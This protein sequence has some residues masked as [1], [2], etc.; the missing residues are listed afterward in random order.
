MISMKDGEVKLGIGTRRMTE[1]VK[2]D[3]NGD[4]YIP[5]PEKMAKEG[6]RLFIRYVSR[7]ENKK[8][9][10]PDNRENKDYDIKCI[11]CGFEWEAVDEEDA[12]PNSC[13]HCRY[14]Y[15]DKPKGFRPPIWK[16][17]GIRVKEVKRVK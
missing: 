9:F 17:V 12:K 7:D 5:I 1:K 4:L 15:W 16:N 3:E 2:K 6:D 8:G 13:P 14:A 10:N 11:R